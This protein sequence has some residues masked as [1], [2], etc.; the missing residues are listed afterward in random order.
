M[1]HPYVKDPGATTAIAVLGKYWP[2][3]L[4]FVGAILLFFFVG[5]QALAFGGALW[6]WVS[7][8]WYLDGAGTKLYRIGATVLLLGA[9][10]VA[11]FSIIV[12]A[13]GTPE[14]L[15]NLLGWSINFL[16]RAATAVAHF[17]AL[18]KPALA[19]STNAVYSFSLALVGAT[20]A[21]L[22]LHWREY[23][24]QCEELLPLC[25][26]VY[27]KAVRFATF[28][29]FGGLFLIADSFYELV[30]L[31]FG[32]GNTDDINFIQPVWTYICLVEGI[33]AT[34]SGFLVWRISKRSGTPLDPV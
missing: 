7:A 19:T 14:I 20:L 4:I 1:I 22:F 24:V 16:P 34:V 15:A 23:I 13:G 17:E 30:E 21:Y 25:G 11:A 29:F 3:R 18:G 31:A 28:H 12:V 32:V 33:S 2:E 9:I 27:P 10:V 5:L 6:I 26:P 8:Y